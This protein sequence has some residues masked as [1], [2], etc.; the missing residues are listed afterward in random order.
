[1]CSQKQYKFALSQNIYAKPL[2]YGIIDKVYT[3]VF[4]N[5][6]KLLAGNQQTKSVFCIC[7]MAA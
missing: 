3:K 4:A 6:S 2:K 7:I 5:P 1:M